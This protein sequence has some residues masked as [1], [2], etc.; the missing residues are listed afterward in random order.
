MCPHWETSVSHAVPGEQT[1]HILHCVARTGGKSKGR[2][3]T[4]LCE[5]YKHPAH[6][7]GLQLKTIRSTHSQK[8]P[9]QQ[10]HTSTLHRGC[11]R[12][13]HGLNFPMVLTENLV[14]PQDLT[15]I[16]LCRPLHDMIPAA[17]RWL[18]SVTQACRR[19]PK[20][21]SPSSS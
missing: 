21:S 11:G 13:Q 9:H 12:S 18:G 15:W 20:D 7:P 2:F 1:V 6:I 3:F 14:P 8:S 10:Q 5:P 4:G 19:R 17:A 16:H